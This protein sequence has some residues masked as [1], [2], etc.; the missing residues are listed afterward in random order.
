MRDIEELAALG[1]SQEACAYFAARDAA[2][3]AQL[4][5]LPYTALLHKPTRQS[6]F[7][8]ATRWDVGLRWCLTSEMTICLSFSCSGS[9]WALIFEAVP[10][11]LMRRTILSRR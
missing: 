3:F 6:H 2:Q 8:N 5:A 11:F 7:P 10:S 4:V 1:A 9:P